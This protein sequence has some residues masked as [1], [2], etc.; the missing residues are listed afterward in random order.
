MA[1]YSFPEKKKKKKKKRE[2]F[3]IRRHFKYM[4]LKLEN[5]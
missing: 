4:K 2:I 5:V 1:S 3:D